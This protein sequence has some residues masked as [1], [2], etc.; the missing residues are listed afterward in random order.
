LPGYKFN[1]NDILASLAKEQFKRLNKIIFE[2]KQI[3]LRYNK[4]L[5]DLINNN[6]IYLPKINSNSESSY[7]CFQIMLKEGNKRIRDKLSIYLKNN[8]ISTTVYY[9]PA[10]EH[11]FYKKKFKNQGKYLKNSNYVFERSL[12]LPMFNGLKNNDIDKICEFVIKFF[13]HG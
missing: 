9:T 7:Y 2:R 12:A 13:K 11:T 6:K 10:N 4:N 8:N 1:Y 3:Y 5:F